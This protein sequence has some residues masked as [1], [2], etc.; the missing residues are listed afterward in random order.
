[1]AA[2]FDPTR[3]PPT[4]ADEMVVKSEEI[5]PDETE[6]DGQERDS[7]GLLPDR[8]RSMRRLLD[9][10]G[11]QRMVRE[12]MEQERGAAAA[13][14]SAAGS[15]AAHA[16]VAVDRDAATE[17]DME[18]SAE[19]E[20][21]APP[22]APLPRPWERPLPP[23]WQR[24]PHPDVGPWDRRDLSWMRGVFARG[25]ACAEQARSRGVTRPPWDGPAQSAVRDEG[26]R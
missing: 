1:M 8:P 25:G 7:A 24:R 4:T 9:P 15:S 13:A 19:D 12:E 11:Y 5:V 17:P 18:E 14:A 16:S 3:A 22:A 21:P 26:A 23:R 6:G 20:A 10:P 2:L